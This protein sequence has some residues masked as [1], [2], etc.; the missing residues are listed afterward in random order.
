MQ[1]A[2]IRSSCFVL[3]KLGYSCILFLS[4]FGLQS[5][6]WLK[7]EAN[8]VSLY[9]IS[10]RQN[11]GRPHRSPRPVDEVSVRAVARLLPV[12]LEGKTLV[13]NMTNNIV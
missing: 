7:V 12:K 2:L 6:H 4:F 8:V 13:I 1:K 9:I 3:G 5:F 11:S 10:L